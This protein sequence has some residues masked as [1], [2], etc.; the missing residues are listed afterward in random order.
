MNCPKCGLKLRKGKDARD[1]FS[2]YLCTEECGYLEPTCFGLG[3]MD[4][5]CILCDREDACNRAIEEGYIKNL[6][7]EHKNKPKKSKS[8]SDKDRTITGI[9]YLITLILIALTIF[10][11]VVEKTTVE[12]TFAVFVAIVSLAGL[13]G[14]MIGKS[15]ARREEE[16]D[17]N[18]DH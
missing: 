15:S 1:N 5:C 8:H 2:I 11:D 17:D 4:A 14:I 16:S 12:C 10:L 9:V 3:N 13:I 6:W 18:R 7:W